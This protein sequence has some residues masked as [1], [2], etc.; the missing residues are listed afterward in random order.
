MVRIRV[1]TMVRHGISTTATGTWYYEYA[2]TNDTMV[3]ASSTSRSTM[4]RCYGTRGR[5]MV[6]TASYY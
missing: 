3:P 1:R 2:N 4:V 5:T 6:R